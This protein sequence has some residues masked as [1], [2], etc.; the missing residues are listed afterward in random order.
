MK[1]GATGFRRIVD[2]TRYTLA[3]VL[4]T[5]LLNSAI[6]AVVWAMIAFDRFSR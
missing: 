5:E 1:P 3:F 6:E 2:A 4:M